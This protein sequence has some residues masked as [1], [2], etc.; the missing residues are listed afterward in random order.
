[1]SFLLP[2]SSI[3]TGKERRHRQTNGNAKAATVTRGESQALP[4]ALLAERKQLKV[5]VF[6]SKGDAI[7]HLDIS[8][9]LAKV[10]FSASSPS[11]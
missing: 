5:N 1:M 7:R 9:S 3:S 8:A 11:S 10:L 2:I 6:V 4:A